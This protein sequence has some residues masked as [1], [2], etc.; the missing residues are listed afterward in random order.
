MT[1]VIRLLETGGAAS[2]TS[3]SW[4]AAVVL[5]LEM[6]R[7]VVVYLSAYPAEL[8]MIFLKSVT[9]VCLVLVSFELGYFGALLELAPL[10]RAV[11]VAHGLLAPCLSTAFS[12]MTLSA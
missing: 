8:E 4:A 5:A 11:I 6:F 3:D 2:S 1:W 10:R 7:L 12:D 9:F